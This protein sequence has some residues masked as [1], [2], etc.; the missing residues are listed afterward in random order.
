MFNQ[1]WSFIQG[2]RTP[3]WLRG[4]AKHGG[5]GERKASKKISQLIRPLE[6]SNQQQ[7]AAYQAELV[8]QNAK[9]EA[10]NQYP[11]APEVYKELCDE[12]KAIRNQKFQQ[13]FSED[14]WADFEALS[15][16][17]HSKGSSHKKKRK[18]RSS[19]D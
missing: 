13:D 12:A 1:L 3:R 9:I 11:H 16:R 7:R 8:Y 2:N 5:M 4:L 18:K 15:K 19:R 6:L 17:A 14:Q 10:W